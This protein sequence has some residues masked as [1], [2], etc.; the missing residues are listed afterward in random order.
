MS[1]LLLSE[2]FI[3]WTRGRT[4]LGPATVRIIETDLEEGRK[5]EDWDW[6]QRER[7]EGSSGKVKGKR[8]CM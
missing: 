2:K 1:L 3:P 6:G 8:L 5:R 4:K 7:R